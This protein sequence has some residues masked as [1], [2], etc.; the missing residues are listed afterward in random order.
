VASALYLDRPFFG[1]RRIAVTLGVGRTRIHR[2]M[3][4]LGIEAHYP[5]RHLSRPGSGSRDLPVL[6][7]R[8]LHRTA[9]PGLEHRYYVPSD[10]WRLPLPGGRNGLVQP[11]ALSRGSASAVRTVLDGVANFTHWHR[12]PISPALYSPPLN[13]SKRLAPHF[14]ASRKQSNLTH[15]RLW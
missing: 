2:L 15:S 6:A 9:Q 7:A 10:A 11:V 12:P 1:G 4:I 13:Y 8:R 5:K 3:R 14:L